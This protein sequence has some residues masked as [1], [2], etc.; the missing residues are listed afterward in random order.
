MGT[1]TYSSA[2]EGRS[3]S[4]EKSSVFSY[5]WGLGRGT[6][7]DIPTDVSYPSDAKEHDLFAPGNVVDRKGRG[8]YVSRTNLD[9]KESLRQRSGLAMRASSEVG[10][11][12]TMV[13][14]V[15][16]PQERRVKKDPVIV[17]HVRCKNPILQS[18]RGFC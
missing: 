2:E 17:H 18:P 10:K 16:T 7:S 14:S 12:L 5:M 6:L 13:S 3:E 15:I 9:D 11:A 8:S 4:Q 1:R